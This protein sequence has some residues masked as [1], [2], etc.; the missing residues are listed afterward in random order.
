MVELADDPCRQARP[1]VQSV[2]SPLYQI[3][4]AHLEAFRGR[5]VIV[6]SALPN[7][8]VAQVRDDDLANLAYIQL[9]ELPDTIDA[10][11]HWAEDVPIDLSMAQPARDFTSLYR[12]AKLLNNHPLRV[13]LPV[14]AGFENAVKLA[15]SL[16]FQ[17]RLLISQPQAAQID[18]LGH[19]LNDYLHKPRVTQPI[20]PFHS[21]LIAFCN[22]QPVSL[23]AIQEEDPRL[24][25]YIDDQGQEHLP[26]RLAETDNK[27]D[28]KTDA[29]PD[30]GPIF[31]NFVATW[32]NRLLAEGAEC[33]DC[34]F[35]PACQGYFKWPERDYDCTGVKTLFATL[36]QA[37]DELRQDLAAAP[38]ATGAGL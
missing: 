28:T 37:G 30:Q 35:F 31:D 18:A 1:S 34:P 19:L 10:L 8:L 36:K 3:P 12:Y 38:P 26:G 11:M 9:C 13:S 20:E 21:L 17:I 15:A 14:E 6:R 27:T 29:A 4:L 32:G 2:T 7:D 5:D 23:W 25:R 33:A 24:I 22:R 16:H